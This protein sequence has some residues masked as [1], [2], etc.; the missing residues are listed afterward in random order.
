MVFLQQNGK[1][2]KIKAEEKE[3]YVTA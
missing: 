1:N 2:S 3:A